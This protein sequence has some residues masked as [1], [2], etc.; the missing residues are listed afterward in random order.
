MRFDGIHT[1][2]ITTSKYISSSER[3]NNGDIIRTIRR[4]ALKSIIGI[5]EEELHELNSYGLYDS[6]GSRRVF[7]E[8]SQE[9][10]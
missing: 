9:S 10:T 4:E 1:A 8:Q 3:F 2:A 6:V 5:A 7:D